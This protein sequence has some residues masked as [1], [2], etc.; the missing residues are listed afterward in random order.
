ENCQETLSD[1][2]TVLV[3]PKPEIT[4]LT[5]VT[6]ICEGE[7]AVFTLEGTPDATVSY[8]INGGATE[9]VVLDATGI[10]TVT[11][12]GA[13]VDQTIGL[14][15]IISIDSCQEELSNTFT[16]VVN[17]NPEFTSLTAVTPICEDEDA[18]FTLEG[19][20]DATVSY[21]I[22]GGATQ[23]IVL[24]ASGTATITVTGATADQTVEITEIIKD[25]C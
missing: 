3:N 13:T 2:A 15:E 17:P 18:V 20:P 9:T 4:S 11:I 16:V 1:T 8:T 7:D 22:N 5:G 12:A 19:T 24:D 25:G 10:A 21:T 14:I 6:P 23:T